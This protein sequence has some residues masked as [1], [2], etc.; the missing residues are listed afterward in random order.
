MKTLKCREPAV[1]FDDRMAI[2]RGRRIGLDDDEPFCLEEAVVEEGIPEFVQHS[3]VNQ[4]FDHGKGIASDL[5]RQPW[6][7]RV[8]IKPGQSRWTLASCASS[9]S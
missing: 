6:I 9:R 1:A 4:I 5:F 7:L 2:C 8:K 3:V